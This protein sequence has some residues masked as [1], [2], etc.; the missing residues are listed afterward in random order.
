MS[1]L[2]DWDDANVTHIKQHGVTPK[3]A[4]EAVIRSPIDLQ[5]EIR[6]GELRVVQIGETLGGK[7]LMVVST[8]R[9][10]KTRIVTATPAKRKYRARYL[11]M[12]EQRNDRTEGPT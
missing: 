3:E 2:F 12:K 4:E 10:D 7:L 6:N 1:I 8:M 5:Y 11:Q 9:G